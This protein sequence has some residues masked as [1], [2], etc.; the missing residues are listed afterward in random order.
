MSDEKN[1]TTEDMERWAKDNPNG[2]GYAYPLH[3]I[4]M[5][6]API[7]VR[8]AWAE[9]ALA[10]GHDVNALHP[11]MGRPLQAA[12]DDAHRTGTPPGRAEN[13]DLIRWLLDHGADPR[14]R[15]LDGRTP[16]D[17][18]WVSGRQ[19]R[20]EHTEAGDA[21]ADFLDQARAMMIEA[22]RKLEDKEAA[23]RGV[24]DRARDFFNVWRDPWDDVCPFCK[25][26][27]HGQK[28]AQPLPDC[29]YCKEEK[30]LHWHYK[31][32]EFGSGQSKQIWRASDFV[33][34]ALKPP[35]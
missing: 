8:L 26:G 33:A 2:G 28:A 1:A 30:E 34:K 21:M 24:V 12:L 35:Y 16:M 25:Y 19:W 10:A 29:S 9:E 23:E 13:L 11:R 4:G 7:A 5:I 22:A 17:I 18:A 20:D 15:D 27:Y 3:D 14:L 31:P 6:F 32:L